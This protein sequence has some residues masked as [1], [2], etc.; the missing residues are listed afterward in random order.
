LKHQGATER[1]ETRYP[2]DIIDPTPFLVWPGGAAGKSAGESGWPAGKC[3][4]GA[5]AR[6]GGVLQEAD[7]ALI[8]QAR[9]EAV[10]ISQAE[11]RETIER[12]RAAHPALFFV[13]R[14]TNDFSRTPVSPEAFVAAIED[15]MGRLI[16]M[17][18]E[19]FEVHASPNLQVEGWERSWDGGREFAVWYLQ[20][21]GMLRAAHPEARLG[22]PGLSPGVTISGQRGDALAFLGEADEALQASDWLGVNCYWSDSAGFESL[23]G[24]RMVDEYRLRFPHHL[25][26]VTEFGNLS[27][28]TSAP[29]KAYEYLAFY[30]RLRT[31]AGVGAA[32]AYALSAV[33]GYVP[34]TWR[35]DGDGASEIAGK[36]GGRGF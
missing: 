10:K 12:L 34:L 32:F 14:L 15:D 36:I 31:R 33:E 22:F 26:F 4:V 11:T 6:L 23:Q 21:L 8:A 29:D 2:K 1:G 19:Y 35:Q 17:G 13:V 28:T 20:V 18:L 30:R 25:I 27:A 5:H 9:L 3:L 7:L 16:R 24:G